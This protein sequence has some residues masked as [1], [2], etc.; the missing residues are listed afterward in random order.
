VVTLEALEPYRCPAFERAPEDPRPLPYLF[1]ENNEK[2]GGIDIGIE[3]HLRTAQMRARKA[4]A[5]R[6]SRGSFRDAYWTI[7]QIVAH[8]SSNGCNLQPGDLLGSGT[9]SGA[10]P[11]SYGSLM[12]LTQGGKAP[13]E[14]ADGEKR[15][16]LEDGDEVIE[17][18]RCA[19][20]GFATI[21][22]GEAAGLIRG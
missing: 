20:E 7:A 8:Q 5:V 4:P 16:F 15:S 17:R 13:L 14:L 1:S 12:E 22:F 2:N 6:L 19:R 9:L 21:G 18:G 10:Q 11:D 3:M